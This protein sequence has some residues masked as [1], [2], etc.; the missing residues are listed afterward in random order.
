MER[1]TLVRL[2]VVLAIGIPVLIEAVTFLGLV[3]TRLFDGDGATTTPAEGGVRPGEELLPDTPQSEVVAEAA[4]RGESTPWVFVLT[5]TVENP[6]DDPYEL[7]L[8]TLTLGGGRTVPG[9]A[10]TGRIPAG[11]S[12]EVTGAWEVPQGATPDRLEV[13]SVRY[14]PDGRAEHRTTVDL[15][16]VPVRG[17]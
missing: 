2:L 16:R 15:G 8:G 4:I 9:E 6:T 11:G 12:G 1:R 7:R 3:E 13:V 17:N 14:G 10:T 5:V